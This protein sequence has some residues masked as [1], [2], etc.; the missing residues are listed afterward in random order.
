M[1][2][3]VLR[4]LSGIAAALPC[5]LCTL[6]AARKSAGRI[7]LVQTHQILPFLPKETEMGNQHYLV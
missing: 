7:E 5:Q 2:C 6:W 1:P 4:L 3:N